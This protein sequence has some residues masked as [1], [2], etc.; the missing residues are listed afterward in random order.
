MRFFFLCI[1]GL[2][3]RMCPHVH[4][5]K[6]NVYVTLYMYVHA[7]AYI[8]DLFRGQRAQGFSTYPKLSF[9]ALNFWKLAELRNF[10]TLSIP[11][12]MYIHTYSAT[13]IHCI[14]L[15]S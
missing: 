2:F 7:C 4:V 9:S 10:N 12:Y 5:Y 6:C 1:N 15:V 8:Y 14:I 13:C 3:A 11:K